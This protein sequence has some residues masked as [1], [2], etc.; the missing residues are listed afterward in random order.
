MTEPGEML[1][2]R[3]A[4]IAPDVKIGKRT[5]CIC[6][7]YLLKLIVGNSFSFTRPGHLGLLQNQAHELGKE[8]VTSFF[9]VFSFYEYNQ[10]CK[11][12]YQS[13]FISTS[14]G[15]QKHPKTQAGSSSSYH[16]P[17]RPREVKWMIS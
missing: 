2:E 9:K 6:C 15:P 12:V 8:E 16:Y 7:L 13:S 14:S 1:L 17:P 11:L 10:I 5:V 4:T 3:N